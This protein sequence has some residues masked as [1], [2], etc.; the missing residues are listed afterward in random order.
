MAPD[1][2]SPQSENRQELRDII[3][4][5][6]RQIKKLERQIRNSTEMSLRSVSFNSAKS[7]VDNIVLQESKRQERFM[8]L[9]L[10]NSP[11]MI[12]LLDQNGRIA[13]CTDSFLKKAGIA[14]FGLVNGRHYR[15]VFAAYGLGEWT[16]QFDRMAQ[17]TAHGTSPKTVTARYEIT[18]GDARHYEIHYAPMLDEQGEVEG[19]IALLHDISDLIR[20]KEQAE[21]ASISKSNFLSSMSHE[22]RTPMNAIIGMS[23]IAK[24]T[25]DLE[26]MRYCMDKIDN[27]SAHLLG[28][29]ND[30]L[31]MSKIE[32]GKF[33][34]SPTMFD[35]EKMM[36]KVAG[37]QTFRIEEKHQEFFVKIS[38][39]IPRFILSD[40]QR[41]AQVVTNLL[42]NAVKFTP[43][44]GR[45]SLLAEKIGENEGRVQLKIS[46]TDTGIGISEQQRRKLFRSFEQGDSGVSRKFGGTGLGLAISKN[47]VEMMGG[48]I[49]AD[50]EAGKGSVFTF[51]LWADKCKDAE[52]HLPSL[53]PEIP[54]GDVRILVVDDSQ[55]V[56]DYFK[57]FGQVQGLMCDAAIS[58]K[59]ALGLIKHVKD[60]YHVIFVDWMMPEMDGL[61]LTRRIKERCGD[62]SVVIM[63]S[64]SSRENIE[65]EALR[66]G[67]ERF[68]PKPLFTSDLL[69]CIA[70][71]YAKEEMLETE[72]AQESGAKEDV[73]DIFAGKRILLVEDVEINREIVMA[74]LSDTQV[75]IQCAE[76][77]GMACRAFQA[78]P[79]A[80]DLILMDV[81]MPVVDGL[82]ATRRIRAM[83]IPRA[84]SIP[85]VAM[86]A[87]VFKEDIDRCLQSGM[88]GHLGKPIDMEELMKTLK[89]YLLGA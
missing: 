72:T 75:S 84:Q 63:I 21:Q 9:L 73:H 36:M 11:D 32:S 48:S 52:K 46:V 34:L 31:D 3:A 62:S 51:T 37:V 10:D 39:E 58:G 67:V 13:Y 76:D 35:F 12:L 61:E 54:W 89:G 71:C 33:E 16:A 19:S 57:T 25:N 45:V 24:S 1:I 30:I 17:E 28:I 85:I 22:I 42:S 74:L 26:K 8:Q 14:N 49:W 7:N 20:A 50:S 41:I 70:R 55:D 83:N 5:Q 18:E 38:P 53:Y 69:D 56:L 68:M 60:P 40:E 6:E 23:S 87:N 88:N 79:D 86:T 82:E 15:D 66:V 44:S 77:G 27:A 80:F 4:Q 43:D 81:Q 29:I 64:S 2:L 59:E 65:E 78:T 47:I